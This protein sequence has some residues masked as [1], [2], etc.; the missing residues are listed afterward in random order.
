M[1]YC[2]LFSIMF[3]IFISYISIIHHAFKNT[4]EIFILFYDFSLVLYIYIGICIVKCS[5]T[6]V[7]STKMP[8]SM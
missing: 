8:L 1:I 7:Y 2:L 5:E 3:P 6:L 4:Q